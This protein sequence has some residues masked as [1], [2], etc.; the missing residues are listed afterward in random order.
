MKVDDRLYRPV[1]KKWQWVK[2]GVPLL[3]EVG[4]RE[5]EAG[6]VTVRRRSDPAERST[7]TIEE[8]VAG[9]G[10]LLEALHDAYLTEASELLAANTRSDVV[11]WAGFEAAF[12]ERDGVSP[13]VRAP[14]CEGATCEEQLKPLAVTIRNLPLDQPESVG[15]CV[16]CG[17]PGTAE[18]VFARSYEADDRSHGPR[19]QNEG[20]SLRRRGSRRARRGERAMARVRR[21]A[22]WRRRSSSDIVS[23]RWRTSAVPATS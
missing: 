4:G 3:L 20:S 11:D 23:A 22:A 18:A 15:A 9:V 2:R 5:A 12:A 7:L 6:T 19:Y 21:S 1:D 17:A 16:L 10:D 14:W 13:F 8:L